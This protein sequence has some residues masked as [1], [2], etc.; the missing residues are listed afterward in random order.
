[1]DPY[2]EIIDADKPLFSVIDYTEPGPRRR[3]K[4]GDMASL[5]ILRQDG[6]YEA[7]TANDYVSWIRAMTPRKYFPTGL[8]CSRRVMEALV[9]R[10][11]ELFAENKYP[12]VPAMRKVWREAW[13]EVLDEAGFTRKTP[14]GEWFGEPGEE[15]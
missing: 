2:Y 13:R 12:P 15:L 8:A 6:T 7:V 14:T 9:P 4:R 11:N 5:G 10:L 1:M 3:S